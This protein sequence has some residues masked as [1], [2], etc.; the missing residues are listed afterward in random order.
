MDRKTIGAFIAVL[1]KANGMTQKD[2]A[3]KLNV[4]DKAVS[5][6]ERDECAPDIS[7]LP[8]IAEIFGVTCDEILRGER[9]P[10][11]VQGGD[12]PAPDTRKTE[13]QVRQMY[14]ASLRGYQSRL[15]YAAGLTVGA[16][17][18]ML[19]CA[20]GFYESVLGF[21]LAMA[22]VAASLIWAVNSTSR[23][24]GAAGDD[25]LGGGQS[26]QY[27]RTVIR[28]F[29]AAV[30]A[31]AATAICL[32]P[33]VLLDSAGYAKRVLQFSA[34]LR[35]LPFCLLVSAA[36]C[37]LIHLLVR[38][39]TMRN[40][41]YA[42]N[43][44]EKRNHRLQARTA[45]RFGAAALA[46]LVAFI[47]FQSLDPIRFAARTRFDSLESLSAALGE[48][49]G[50]PV[51]SRA[52]SGLTGTRWYSFTVNAETD[53]GEGARRA[54]AE[55]VGMLYAESPAAML[56]KAA[57]TAPERGV[58]ILPQGQ[59]EKIAVRNFSFALLHIGSPE[60]GYA[61]SYGITWD[62]LDRAVAV[63]S[64][65]SLLLLAL[66]LAVPAMGVARYL[67]KRER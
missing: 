38:G 54:K 19:V 47:A 2:F 67:R 14:A 62:S 21:G 40:P 26:A 4:S 7:L 31:N 45:A 49:K 5:R 55:L 28:Y 18:V 50:D 29:V 41:Q 8:V 27:R 61:G 48:E 9:R 42:Y 15:L 43:D 53:Y 30:C 46:L 32:S 11:S 58:H 56:P 17:L 60:G 36:V 24:L 25:E 16:A 63:H 59:A 35:T 39:R 37:L 57:E 33:L 34:W 20:Y 10:A 64:L 44:K 65:A 52:Y 23:A 51:M 13:K 3:E 6:W 12:D 22:L 1:R 66:C